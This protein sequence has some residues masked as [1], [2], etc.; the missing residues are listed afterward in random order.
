MARHTHRTTITSTNVLMKF[1]TKGFMDIE[2][3][4]SLVVAA[5]SEYHRLGSR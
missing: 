4:L 3:H 2:Y 5:I 1:V